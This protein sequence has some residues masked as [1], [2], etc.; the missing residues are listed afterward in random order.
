MLNIIKYDLKGNFKELLII[1]GSIIFLNIILI[2]RINALPKE[3]IIGFSIMITSIASIIIFLFNINLLSKDIYSDNS[4]L[5]FTLP[6]RG[7]SIL[8]A[9]LITAIIQFFIVFGIASI[10]NFIYIIKLGDTLML[11]TLREIFN[12]RNIFFSVIICM[13]FNIEFLTHVFFSITASKMA[14]KKNKLGK[15]GAFGIF[16]AISLITGKISMQLEEKIPKEI[17]L[18]IFSK[19][20]YFTNVNFPDLKLNLASLIFEIFIFIILYIGTCYILENKMDLN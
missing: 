4:Y 1:I 8:T 2:T 15:L 9:K 3:G 5:L 16:V 12:F 11:L 7:Y 14:L 6:E 20:N 10:F 19:Q 18:T 17:S 13:L